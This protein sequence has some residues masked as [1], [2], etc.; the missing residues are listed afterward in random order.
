MESLLSQ[1]GIG[2]TGVSSNSPI[3]LHLES[4][5]VMTVISSENRVTESYSVI[6]TVSWNTSQDH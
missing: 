5:V 1:C 6:S 4:E 3:V 2:C